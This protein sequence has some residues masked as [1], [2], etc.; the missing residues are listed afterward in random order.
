MKWN[1]EIYTRV[2]EG[3]YFKDLYIGIYL[4]KNVY[5]KERFGPNIVGLSVAWA[6]ERRKSLVNGRQKKW[7]YA[8]AFNSE[9]D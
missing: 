1:I 2:L 9:D 7:T 8:I 6:E 5:A 4:I 3:V